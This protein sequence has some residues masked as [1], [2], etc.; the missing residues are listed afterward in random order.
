MLV[1]PHPYNWHAWEH[2]DLSD[3]GAVSVWPRG[4]YNAVDEANRAGFFD[5]MFHAAA[6][7][8]VNTSAMI[9]SAIVG[10]PV[11][12]LTGDFAGTQEGTLH[13]RH[14]LPE[15][16]GFLRVAATFEEHLRQLAGVLG[17][18]EAATAETRRFVA[19]FIR[20]HGIETPCTPIL[21]D[22]IERFASGPA[23]VADRDGLLD[24]VVRTALRPVAALVNRAPERK[25]PKGTPK[26]KARP[27]KDE[28][29]PKPPKPTKAP[30]A[31]PVAASVEKPETVR[32]TPATIEAPVVHPP[33]RI[34]PAIVTGA[35]A[36]DPVAIFADVR[37]RVAAILARERGLLSGTSSPSAYWTEE[38]GNIDYMIEATP[39]VIAKLRHHA[40]HITGLRPYD[41]RESHGEKRVSFEARLRAL[42]ELGGGSLVV[43]EHP[44][45]GGFGFEIDSTLHNLD[46]LKYLEVLTG[47]HRT[48]ML[49][50]VRA[51]A[52]ATRD[53]LSRPV[54]WEIGAGW[55]GFAYQ[56]TSLVTPCTYV[57]TDFPEL[58]L[59]SAT[60]LRTVRPSAKTL[61]WDP[62]MPETEKARWREYDVVF[63]PH[64]RTHELPGF[65]PSLL[66]NIASF[67]EMRAD[68]VAAYL[69]LAA[70]AGCPRVYSLNREHSAHN[71]ELSSVSAIL[72]R[73]YVVQD[74]TLLDT[75][76]TSAM[77]KAPR[78]SKLGKGDRT[79]SS[80]S[81]HYRH[82][83]GRTRR[84]AGPA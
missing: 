4:P 26:G 6:V 51:E 21:A 2:A 54:V 84:G 43:P 75:D 36:S 50:E 35:A 31:T 41:Y 76:Y 70:K 13:F 5:S 72:G 14:L 1:R 53:A 58:F 22:T 56:F 40:F 27:P 73:D 74:V 38:L 11:F 59:F 52:A 39:L 79:Q 48:G 62:A 19:S 61:I 17:N 23:P 49:D 18:P 67:Q 60:Y 30:K 29:T 24:V 3:L 66:V 57:I 46:T 37:S 42:L 77:K 16:G 81:L 65:A 28:R 80:D 82:L 55:G 9:E 68:Q 33:V 12:S 78:A 64:T 34:H 45:L 32:K 44:A 10:R 83:T 8:G 69:D 20:P 63:V 71:D 25:K 15:N 7:V 47:L